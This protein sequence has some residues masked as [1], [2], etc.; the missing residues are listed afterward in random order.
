MYNNL[1]K[2]YHVIILYLSVLRFYVN[3]GIVQCIVDTN[4]PLSCKYDQFHKY[5]YCLI[6][7]LPVNEYFCNIK[8]PVFRS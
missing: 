1:E 7:E 8:R 5:Y 3:Y 6:T 2:P 4:Q